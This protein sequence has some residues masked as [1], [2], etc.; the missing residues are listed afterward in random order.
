M[1]KQ[2]MQLEVRGLAEVNELL[3]GIEKTLQNKVLRPALRDVAKTILLPRVRARIPKRSGFLARQ[4]TVRGAKGAGGKR[5]PRGRF[6][7]SVGFKEARKDGNVFT[8]DSFYG[9][10]LEWGTKKHK[11]KPTHRIRAHK[12]LRSSLYDSRPEMIAALASAVRRFIPRIKAK[13]A[14]SARAK[15]PLLNDSQ[16]NTEK[17]IPTVREWDEQRIG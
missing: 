3:K 12:F 10:I 6:G 13:A 1:T 2:S 5:L 15:Q 14:A 17:P 9:G 8:G 7:S 4:L 11:T 16:F